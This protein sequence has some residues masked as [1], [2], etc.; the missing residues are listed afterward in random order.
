MNICEERIMIGSIV[1]TCQ[2]ENGHKELHKNDQEK[3]VKGRI[4]KIIVEW[5]DE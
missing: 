1:L 3:H 5:G 4:V 2:L